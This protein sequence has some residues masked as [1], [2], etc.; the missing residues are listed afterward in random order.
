MGVGRPGKVPNLLG[1]VR[2]LI[3]NG[4]DPLLVRRIRVVDAPH[5]VLDEGGIKY[6]PSVLR[7]VLFRQ[8]PGDAYY[9]GARKAQT[10]VEFRK[11]GENVSGERILQGIRFNEHEGLVK[12]LLRHDQFLI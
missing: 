10:A 4:N 2:A 9:L 7:V 1:G 11:L 8:Y 3:Y 5:D 12:F 6:L